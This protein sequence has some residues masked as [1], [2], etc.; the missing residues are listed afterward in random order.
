M[1]VIGDG[2]PS[3]IFYSTLTHRN[4]H[5]ITLSRLVYLISITNRTIIPGCSLLST[6]RNKS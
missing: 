3:T 6:S 4:D 2:N 1:K 5:P